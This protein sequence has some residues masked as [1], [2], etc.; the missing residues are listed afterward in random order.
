MRSVQGAFRDAGMKFSES[1]DG[2]LSQGIN[3]VSPEESKGLEFDAVVVIEP[4]A[5]LDMAQGA[6]L[7]YIALTRTVH[8]LDVVLRS[9][10]IP[11]MLEEFIPNSNIH[12]SDINGEEAN[13]G[14]Q[15]AEEDKPDKEGREIFGESVAS[16][17]AHGV[18]AEGGSQVS[19]VEDAP[20]APHTAS[21][22]AL[23]PMLERVA[24]TMATDFF[25]VLREMSPSVQQR[26]VDLL[27]DKM[28]GAGPAD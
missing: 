2:G 19:G 13:I 23:K 3:L 25:E 17:D 7:L 6:K 12:G 20:D 22:G 4:K 21:A 5:I 24:Q 16:D 27:W 26:V 1:A 11:T 15:V 9:N 28:E 14:Q 18:P 10:R 8:H